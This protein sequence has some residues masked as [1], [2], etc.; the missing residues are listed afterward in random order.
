MELQDREQQYKQSNSPGNYQESLLH[1][2]ENCV[3]SMQLDWE[4]PRPAE[5]YA[6]LVS[7]SVSILLIPAANKVCCLS[8]SACTGSSY[9]PCIVVMIPMCPKLIVQDIFDHNLLKAVLYRCWDEV[10]WLALR[11]DSSEEDSHVQ[12]SCWAS[13]RSIVDLVGKHGK[14]MALYTSP[15]PAQEIEKV[16]HTI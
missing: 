6:F 10:S 7:V 14:L 3:K 11:T 8:S 5:N 15:L 12:M 16:Q 9:G 1:L 13:S 2:L 4:A